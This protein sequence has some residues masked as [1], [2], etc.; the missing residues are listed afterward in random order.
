VVSD[1][2]AFNTVF[3]IVSERSGAN[4]LLNMVAAHPELCAPLPP[5]FFRQLLINGARYG[6]LEDDRNWTAL[7]DDLQAFAQKV[8]EPW[9]TK[10]TVADFDRLVAR[11]S[12]DEA[13]RVYVDAERQSFGARYAL[14]KENEVFRFMP[15]LLVAFPSSRFV[16]QVRDPRDMLA[17]FK[18]ST[19]FSK[20]IPDPVAIW[21][22]EQQ[23][24]LNTYPYLKAQGR[25]KFQRYEDLI[26][27]PEAALRRLCGFFGVDYDPEMLDYYKGERARRRAG[28]SDLRKNVA[29]PVLSD[30]AGKYHSELTEDEIRMVETRVGEL[31]EM[32]GYRLEFPPAKSKLEILAERQVTILADRSTSLEDRQLRS[33]RIDLIARMLNRPFPPPTGA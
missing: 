1:T 27:E 6:D 5:H 3:F 22:L 24:T 15:A 17:S 21:E 8:S 4:L 26:G 12:V 7:V 19:L 11:R 16:W 13:L 23:Q 28:T 30:N 32:L 29:K 33:D 14:L 9:A 25:I 20:L 10:M 2:S 18:R 31:M